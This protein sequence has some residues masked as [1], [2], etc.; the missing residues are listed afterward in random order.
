MRW[1]RRWGGR[2][3]LRLDRAPSADQAAAIALDRVDPKASATLQ[4][5]AR[6][7]LDAVRIEHAMQFRDI[8]GRRV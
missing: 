5:L 1:A 3:N 2:P 7:T 8:L 6:E 4:N